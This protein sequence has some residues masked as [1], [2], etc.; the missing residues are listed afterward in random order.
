M[1]W[2]L[3]ARGF[4]ARRQRTYLLEIRMA[5]RD[6]LVLALAAALLTGFFALHL[7]GWD[8]IPGLVIR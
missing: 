4:Q 5:P 3:E 1:S 8:R 6:W 7:A 2:A